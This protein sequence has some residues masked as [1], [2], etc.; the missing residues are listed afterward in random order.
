MRRQRIRLS[1][2]LALALILTP[3]LAVREEVNQTRVQ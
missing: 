3:A 2:T 1:L